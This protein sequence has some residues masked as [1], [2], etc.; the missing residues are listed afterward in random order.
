MR[1]VSLVI[2]MV[3]FLSA[4]SYADKG[5]V[6]VKSAHPVKETADRLE[7]LLRE[8]GIKLFSRIDHAAGARQVGKHLR[9]TELLIF[10]NP[11]MGSPLMICGQTVAIDLPQKMLIWEDASGDVWLSYNAPRYLVQRHDISACEDTI[12]MMESALGNIAKAATTQP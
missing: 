9:P 4:P 12:R 1:A 3:L 6:S 5:L 10:G 11:K 8:K 7:S 2:L